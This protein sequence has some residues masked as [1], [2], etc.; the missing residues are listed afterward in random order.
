MIYKTVLF[1]KHNIAFLGKRPQDDKSF[2]IKEFK[3]LS[4][5]STKE[6]KSDRFYVVVVD[7]DPAKYNLINLDEIPIFDMSG[8]SISIEN[9]DDEAIL[10]TANNSLKHSIETTTY[11]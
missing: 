5:V 3:P 8:Q 10:H 7:D 2:T 6:L 4:F 11:H 9:V 1:K